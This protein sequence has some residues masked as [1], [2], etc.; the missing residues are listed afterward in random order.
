MIADTAEDATRA[1]YGCRRRRITTSREPPSAGDSRWSGN[2]RN[3][4]NLGGG[5]TSG[6]TKWGYTLK[7][8]GLQIWV[9]ALQITD[10]G[11]VG[12]FR[13]EIKK[14]GVECEA[15]AP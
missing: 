10:V 14:R 12:I 11:K 5:V 7:K 15:N 2:S 9:L 1:K 3:G 13:N 8:V 4:S 6:V